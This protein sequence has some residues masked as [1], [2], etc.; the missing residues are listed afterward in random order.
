[1]TISVPRRVVA[2]YCHSKIQSV[3]VCF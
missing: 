2:C 1:M 3:S